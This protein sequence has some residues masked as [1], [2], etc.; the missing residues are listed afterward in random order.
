[1]HDL[2]NRGA[3]AL[4]G[5]GVLGLT[6][7]NAGGVQAA[8]E[9]AGLAEVVVTGSRIV[10]P[11]G[12]TTPTP[13]TAVSSEELALMSP[14]TMISALTQLPQFYNSSSTEA[15][16]NF[17]SSPGMGN[18][19]L[20]GLNTGGNSSRTLTLLDGRRVV[21]ANRFGGVDINVLPESLV[22]R[23]ETV[24]GGASAAYGTDAVTGVVNFILDTDYTGWQAHAQTG[25]TDRGDNQRMELA[26]SFGTNIGERAHLLLN[27]EYYQHDGVFGFEGRNWFDSWGVVTNPAGGTPQELIRPQ[28]VSTASTFGGLIT[29]VPTTSA[30]YRQYFNPNSSLAQ[31]VLGEGTAGDTTAAR[32]LGSHSIANGGSGDYIGAD[33]QSLTP[34]AE[35]ANAFVYFDVDATPNLNLYVQGLY[36][37]SMIDQPDHGGRFNDPNSTPLTIYRE[38]AFLPAAVQ[39][40]MDAEGLTS[41]RL[42][43]HGS[44]AGMGRESR[45]KQE[46]RT[47]SGTVGFKYNVDSSGFF[48]DWFVEGY[49]QYGTA[50]NRGDQQGIL[51]DRVTAAIDAVVDP[52]NPGNIVC[53]AATIDPA[54]WGDCVPLNLFGDGNASD[55]ALNYV[56]RFPAGQQIT[57]PLYF[58]RDGYDRGKTITYTSGYGKVYNTKTEQ[59]VAELTASGKIWDGW[60]AGAVAAAIGLSYREEE[61]EQ[62]VYDPSNPASD[63]NFFPARDPALRGVSSNVNTRTSMV[64]NSTVPNIYGGYDVKEVFTELHLPLLSDVFLARQLTFNGAARYADYEGSG[65]IWAWKYGIDWQMFDDLR[66]RGTVSRDIRAATLAERYDN[67]GGIGTVNP[68]PMFPNDGVQQ[69]TTRSGGNPFLNP[70]EADT[71]TFGFVYRPGWFPG[72]SL[73]V[74]YWDIDIAGAIGTLG[75]QRIVDDCYAGSDVLCQLVTREPG[76]NRLIQVANVS[77]NIAAAAGNGVDVEISYARAIRLFRDSGEM[78]SARLFYARLDEN[79]T[80]P[81]NAPTTNVAGQVGLPEDTVTANLTYS[82]G[83]FSAFV[84]GRYIGDTLRNVTHVEGVR[85]DDNSIDSAIYVDLRLGYTWDMAGGR[86][87]V[88]GNVLNLLD[89]APALV[90]AFDTLSASSIETAP[91]VF[92]ALGRRYTIGVRFRY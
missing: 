41:F 58:T 33:L 44:R 62:I 6:L 31:F 59:T 74:D 32:G 10:L 50:D 5:A 83:A 88:Y 66:L 34:D 92:D 13:V 25:F 60:G 39:Q 28:V 9:D 57:T 61:V 7:A 24:T 14:G 79:S 36:G 91:G 11:T 26:A 72:F 1:M 15:V 29:G 90:P 80:T 55:A 18:L 2:S 65:G 19:N 87:E 17:F 76:T 27:A 73:S 43:I 35:R 69:F 42:N 54:K 3:R 46:N 30:L 89:E 37:R 20:R 78:L 4:L 75:L 82:T 51:L 12:M 16:G 49:A 38:N 70:E 56:T 40:T 77:Q 23:V 67:T 68:D 81:L 8:E 45:L 52:N 63:P 64:Q 71:Y 22:R 53:R 84:Q 21:P 48:D 47:Y 85:I 86:M